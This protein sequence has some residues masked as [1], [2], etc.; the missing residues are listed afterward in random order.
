MLVRKS[1]RIVARRPQAPGQNEDAFAR[2]NSGTTRYRDIR[3]RRFFM[4]ACSQRFSSTAWTHSPRCESRRSRLCC[5][6]RCFG[7]L[8]AFLG[9]ACQRSCSSCFVFRDS[10]PYSGMGWVAISA[11]SNL[12]TRATRALL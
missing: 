4:G 2:I 11:R 10:G 9:S 3:W 5:D 1:L 7:P 8:L 12:R 6:V